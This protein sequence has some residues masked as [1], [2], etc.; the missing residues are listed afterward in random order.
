M[1]T[2]FAI[3]SLL[4][5]IVFCSKSPVSPVNGNS[6]LEVPIYVKL[7]TQVSVSPNQVYIYVNGKLDAV[8]FADKQSVV[9]TISVPSGCNLHSEYE[10]CYSGGGCYFHEQ[11]TTAYKGMI[12]N[13]R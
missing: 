5:V 7:P 13:I 10:Y 12:W 1:K 9:D 6:G 4:L 2:H 11:D 3:I 8:L